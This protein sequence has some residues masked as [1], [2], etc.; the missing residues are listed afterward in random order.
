MMDPP[1]AYHIHIARVDYN[2]GMVAHTLIPST[3]EGKEDQKFKI[4][5][6]YL[7]SS[8]PA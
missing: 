4:R 6:S 8:R 5:L 3:Y 7:V 2:S 1:A